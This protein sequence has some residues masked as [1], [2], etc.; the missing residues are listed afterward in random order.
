MDKK[1]VIDSKSKLKNQK[2][3]IS[4]KEIQESKKMKK[5]V[6][7]EHEAL[8]NIQQDGYFLIPQDQQ[9]SNE[10]EALLAAFMGGNN[11]G[12]LQQEIDRRVEEKEQ[13]KIKESI[14]N[15]PKV[16]VVYGDVANLM[17]T[18]TNGQLSKPFKAIPHLE[19]W[20]EVLDLTIPDEW[21]ANATERA[22]RF[23][24]ANLDNYRA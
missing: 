22:T 19:Q 13:Q 17:K 21:S 12:T 15:D 9:I 5:D 24:I 2:N 1:K 18:Y 7:E 3:K 20:K 10:E 4:N 14:L 16:K 23:L 6:F 11:A 8:E